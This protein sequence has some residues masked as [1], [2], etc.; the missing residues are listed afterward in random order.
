MKN[1]IITGRSETK[2]L[3]PD[4]YKGEDHERASRETEKDSNLKD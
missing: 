4:R 1:A 2:K 3:L